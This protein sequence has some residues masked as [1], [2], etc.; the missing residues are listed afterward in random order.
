MK[1][2]NPKPVLSV[3]E[4]IRNNIEGSKF[5][6]SKRPSPVG[7]SVSVIRILCFEFVSDFVFRI[8][9]LNAV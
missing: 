7:G 2:Q 4:W 5:K 6:G 3:V 1:A 8:S 9:D